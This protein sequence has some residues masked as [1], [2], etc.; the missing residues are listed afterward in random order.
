MYLSR[1]CE[2]FLIAV[3]T[4]ARS[5]FGAT[6]VLEGFLAPVMRILCDEGNR[7]ILPPLPVEMWAK[8]GNSILY[9]TRCDPFAGVPKNVKDAEKFQ[10]KL[11]WQISGKKES[12]SRSPRLLP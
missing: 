9:Y 4:C 10:F 11:L 2:I 6:L 7:P 5:K 8:L 1:C 3:Y 12:W